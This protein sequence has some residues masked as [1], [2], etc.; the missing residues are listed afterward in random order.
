MKFRPCIDLHS[1]KVKQIVGGTLKDEGNEAAEN[2]V[3]D[4]S[5][6]YYAKMYNRDALAGGH[7]IMLGPGN[8][9]AAKQALLAYPGGLQ[10]GGGINPANARKW[11]DAGAS[12]VIITSFLFV[13]GEL[14]LANLDA[15]LD[16]VGGREKL[17][18]DLSCRK[19]DGDYYVVVDRWQ[20]FTKTKVD[21][22]TLALLGG[23]C[24]EFL[25]HGVDVEGTRLGIDDELV[26]LLGEAS[27]VPVTYAGGAASLADLDRVKEIGA[28]KVDL[29]IG[30]ALS[31]FGGAIPYEDVLAWQAGQA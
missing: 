5:A 26:R 8:E 18:I 13:K 3:S 29:T 24:A 21:R 9:R 31:I 15:V 23:S 1:G 27:P 28:G 7:V 10:I 11:L 22:D 4:K 12:H 2:F 16:V 14:S 19:K 20:T 30:S 25:V 6:E 17:V